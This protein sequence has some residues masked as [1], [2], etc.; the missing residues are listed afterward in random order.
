MNK[1]PKVHFLANELQQPTNPIKI[2]L[3]GAGGT[4]SFFLSGLARLN[5]ALTAHG[6]AGLDVRLWDGDRVST[7]N[8]GRQLFATSE[9]GLYKSVTLINRINRFF[10][11]S[12]SA[13][14][15]YFSNMPNGI[16]N[17]ELLASIY[18][19]CVDNIQTRFDLST[20]LN[21]TKQFNNQVNRPRYWI[22]LGNSK[23]TGQIICSTIGHIAQPDSRKFIP[24][25]QLPFITEE[26]ESLLRSGE[27]D[28]NTPSCSLVDSLKKQSLFINS[29]LANLGCD[30]LTTLLF[31]GC[32][33]E[34]GIL[35]N[36]KT[37]HCRPLPF[38]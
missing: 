13:E 35:L 26:F 24:V 31:E 17:S 9:I 32:L 1:L 11:T 23:D 25:G 6:H 3:I 34:R 14:A 36:L 37:R 12:W 7:N 10:G 29:T 33:M 4:G 27:K 22:D 2:N 30:M 18:I 15:R 16:Q 19:S 28:D 8:I 21:N 20:I 38:D 5:E